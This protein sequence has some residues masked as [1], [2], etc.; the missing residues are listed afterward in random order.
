MAALTLVPAAITATSNV[1]PSII[2]IGKDEAP[3]TDTLTGVDVIAGA[4][5]M[6]DVYTKVAEAKLSIASITSATT[7]GDYTTPIAVTAN[8]ADLAAGKIVKVGSDLYVKEGA[9]LEATVVLKAWVT[10]AAKTLTASGTI[11]T[12]V[13][14]AQN[15]A[16]DAKA[17]DEFTFTWTAPAA[18]DGSTVAFVIT[19]S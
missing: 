19:E 3:I 18:A 8:A 2:E 1:I 7:A 9:K 4:T 10:A 6:A 14:S 11:F 15:V 12:T 13:S 5:Y 17:G 16:A